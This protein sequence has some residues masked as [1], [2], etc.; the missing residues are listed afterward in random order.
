MNAVSRLPRF[1][2]R[3]GVAEQVGVCIKTVDRWIADGGLKVY[4]LGRR[5]R[6]AE[7]DLLEFLSKHR[8]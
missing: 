2:S 1:F 7:G 3:Q 6:I 4:R 5:V 8:L